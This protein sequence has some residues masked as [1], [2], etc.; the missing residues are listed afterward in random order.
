MGKSLPS[1]AEI[2][3]LWEIWRHAQKHVD[4]FHRNIDA[5]ELGL[6]LEARNLAKENFKAAMHQL[7]DLA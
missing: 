6:A 3:R 4:S 2:Y 5:D 1:R 7:K